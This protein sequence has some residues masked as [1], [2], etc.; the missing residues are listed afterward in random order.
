[1]F[2]LSPGPGSRGRVMALDAAVFIVL[3]L[4]PGVVTL[5]DN[6]RVSQDV[7]VTAGE[8]GLGDFRLGK[9]GLDQH[10]LVG[11]KRCHCKKR[12]Q[13]GSHG[14]NW[15]QK[16]ALTHLLDLLTS[17]HLYIYSLASTRVRPDQPVW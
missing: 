7:T 15:K 4:L 14:K 1:M 6:A 5:H 11:P 3:A 2:D 12:C 13:Q 9:L 17:S 16:P 10:L 8:L